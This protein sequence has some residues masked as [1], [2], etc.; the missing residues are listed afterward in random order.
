MGSVLTGSLSGFVHSAFT[1]AYEG[2]LMKSE[3]A[4]AELPPGAL[5]AY[6][7]KGLQYV[8]IESQLHEV[9][10]SSPKMSVFFP[11][12]CINVSNTRMAPRARMR[13]KP[14]L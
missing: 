12:L 8:S 11:H 14:L 2:Q 13:V 6:L 5:I 9:Q 3:L 10:L 1:F 7:Q 4:S